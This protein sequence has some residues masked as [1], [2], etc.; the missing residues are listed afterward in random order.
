MQGLVSK[1]PRLH[2]MTSFFLDLSFAFWFF[3][4]TGQT[5]CIYQKKR[6]YVQDLVGG[7]A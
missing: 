6:I 3:F 7:Q 2:L 5:T 4:F 1:L